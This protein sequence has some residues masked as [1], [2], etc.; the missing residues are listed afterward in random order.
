MLFPFIIY[1]FSP[2]GENPCTGL[3]VECSLGKDKRREERGAGP[4]LLLAA[5]RLLAVDGLKG[6]VQRRGVML[7]GLL[8]SP[9]HPTCF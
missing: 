6:Q 3:R 7:G 4:T 2:V 8:S 9:N 1:A 5:S